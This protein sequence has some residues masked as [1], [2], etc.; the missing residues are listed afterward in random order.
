MENEKTRFREIYY[1][2]LLQQRQENETN[3]IKIA[4]IS[5]GV[6]IAGVATTIKALP[7]LS[8]PL[9]LL[10]ILIAG[11][12]PWLNLLYVVF[13]KL[14]VDEE[15]IDEKI[16]R[17]GE[18]NENED[19]PSKKRADKLEEKFR[20]SLIITLIGII[21]IP[22]C[23][24]ISTL[25]IGGKEVSKKE[26][27]KEA[28]S[29]TTEKETTKEAV[30][31]T[32]EKETAKKAV[33]RTTDDRRSTHEQSYGGKLPGFIQTKPTDPNQDQEVTTPQDTGS[34]PQD[35]DSESQNQDSN[36]GKKQKKISNFDFGFAEGSHGR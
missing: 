22:T 1:S 25:F 9:L 16:E 4:L 15:V 21:C 30:S 6:T 12:A 32:T 35:T 33:S 31:R 18:E 8:N 10:L 27:T 19:P 26:T 24:L 17:I 34:D 14:K 13:R 23:I 7:P 11:Y 2:S 36:Q 3:R 28:V 20:R 29:R 5:I